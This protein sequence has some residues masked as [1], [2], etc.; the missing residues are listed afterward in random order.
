LKLISVK[1]GRDRLD[2]HTSR[3]QP[4]FTC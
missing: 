2:R 1:V 4:T 3:L